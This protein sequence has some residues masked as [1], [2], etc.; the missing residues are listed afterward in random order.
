[1]KVKNIVFPG[2]TAVIMGFDTE[3]KAILRRGKVIGHLNDNLIEG[4]DYVLF[5]NFEKQDVYLGEHL[6]AIASNG[7]SLRGQR[8]ETKDE[9]V[10]TFTVEGD[11][12]VKLRL[13][14]KS[15]FIP[16]KLHFPK[17]GL[18]AYH[19]TTGRKVRFALK[20]ETV[21]AFDVIECV[22][23]PRVNYQMDVLC[24]NGNVINT[25]PINNLNIILPFFKFI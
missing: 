17:K 11:S 16:P 7:N 12:S 6:A 3:T 19:Y 24:E 8:F 1:M 14:H 2:T 9:L 15:L 5:N 21:L 20:R 13:R 25:F 10:S 23:M 18:W 4:T 22:S